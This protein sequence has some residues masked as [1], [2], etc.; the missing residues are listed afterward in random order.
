M[1]GWSEIVPSHKAAGVSEGWGTG[2]SGM[3]VW[4]LGDVAVAL[5]VAVIHRAGHVL[6]EG[7]VLQSCRRRREDS[8]IRLGSRGEPRPT[9]SCS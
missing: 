5:V 4:R 2:A 7:R 9:E 3:A 8:S 1:D 6:T